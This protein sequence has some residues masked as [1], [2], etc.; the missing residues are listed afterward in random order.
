MLLFVQLNFTLKII[1]ACTRMRIFKVKPVCYSNTLKTGIE[2][3]SFQLR[4][5]LIMEQRAVNLPHLKL[6]PTTSYCHQQ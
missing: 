6:W 5:L 4:K 2:H 3:Y 1:G